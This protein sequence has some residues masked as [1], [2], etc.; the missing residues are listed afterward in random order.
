MTGNLLKRISVRAV[1]CSEAAEAAASA[2]L[3]YIYIYIKGPQT[4]GR[5]SVR[6]SP[7]PNSL[8]IYGT[9][10]YAQILLWTFSF[11]S[12][13]YTNTLPFILSPNSVRNVVKLRGP[14]DSLS[15]ASSTLASGSLPET[16][17]SINTVK[18]AHQTPGGTPES[19]PVVLCPRDRLSVTLGCDAENAGRGG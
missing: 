4:P 17:Y 12:F 16:Q 3:K 9:V 11:S 18:T 10:P 5:I 14:G 7:R 15:M 8:Q 19:L 13:L 6:R 1:N 2:K